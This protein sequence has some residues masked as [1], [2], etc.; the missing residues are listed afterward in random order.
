MKI[1][2]IVGFEEG[3]KRNALKGQRQL[4]YLHDVLPADFVEGAGH[5]HDQ[6]LKVS[7][8]TLTKPLKNAGW[9]SSALRWT[10]RR[11]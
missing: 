4:H 8:A 11:L 5:V 2:K 3:L 6:P 10:T 9:T 7:N 1:R